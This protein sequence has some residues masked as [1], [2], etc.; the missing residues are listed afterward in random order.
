VS[1][2]AVTGTDLN[3]YIIVISGDCAPDGSITL[4]L[5]EDKSCTI[6]NIAK[7]DFSIRKLTTIGGVEQTD[8]SWTFELT[9]P[10]APGGGDVTTT[11]TS[12]TDF[13][14]G[15][16]KLIPGESY[17]LCE[18][19][20]PAGWSTMWWIDDGDIE[21]V[22][23][24]GETILPLYNPNATDNPPQDLGT[25]CFDFGEGTDYPLV[26]GET[27]VFGA[28]NAFPGGEPRTIG[29]WKNWNY[30]SGGNQPLTAWE[31][32]GPAAGF[33]IL[34]DV[35]NFPG[36]TIGSFTIPGTEPNTGPPMACQD[37]A[38]VARLLLDKRDSVT[39]KNMARDAAY[40]LASQLIAAKAN[41]AAGA[42]SCDDLDDAILEA[43]ALLTT[44]LF[45]G[46]DG[47]LSSK[48]PLADTYRQPALDLAKTLDDYNNGNLCTG[49]LDISITSPA[50]N[51]TVD[52]S[53]VSI[54]A[55]VTA[56]SSS[57]FTVG[58]VEF[59]VDGVGIGVDVDDTD[60]WSIDWD[61]TTVPDGDHVI[62]ATA[63]D[64]GG[65]L[66]SD[67]VTVTVDNVVDVTVPMHLGSRAAV[68]STVNANKWRAEV[69]IT[70]HDASHNPVDGAMVFA[71]WSTGATGSCTTDLSGQC[72]I[73]LNINKSVS[74]V[75][76]NV[77]DITHTSFSYQPGGNDV[78][79]SETISKP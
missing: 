66:A 29:Y 73:K 71:S 57:L 55:T 15:G 23:E 56:D 9:G 67:E 38:E 44:I 7:V 79:D 36:I 2:T 4:G 76:F 54:T 61:S 12:T 37:G 46:T 6:T 1:E 40:E 48:D 25:R 49:G 72:T 39:E 14:F 35:L 62:T 31:N 60:G 78:V 20:V 21:G 11:Q 5:D 43:D 51:S 70:V 69:T 64:S 53:A 17:T 41:I 3:D 75:T 24:N 59:Y 74:S 42:A 27:L 58:R 45:D 26:P 63:L 52:G 77:D 68:S 34:E 30:C 19:G 65:N 22:F 10:D 32:G 28:L 33:F 8:I 50:D 47:Y 16:R 13:N 18:V